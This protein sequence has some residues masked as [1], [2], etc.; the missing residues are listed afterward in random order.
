MLSSMEMNVAGLVRYWRKREEREEREQGEERV[1]G[2]KRMDRDER[3]GPQ[4]RG[5]RPQ[6][7]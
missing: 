4:G 7:P 6:A 3:E 5:D 2:E 1:Q